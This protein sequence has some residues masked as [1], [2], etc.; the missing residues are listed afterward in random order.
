MEQEEGNFLAALDW[1]LTNCSDLG[2]RR[3]GGGAD[4]GLRRSAEPA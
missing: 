4:P 2:L 1:A 3:G